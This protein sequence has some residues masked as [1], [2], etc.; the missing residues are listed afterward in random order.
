MYP[1]WFINFNKCTHINVLSQSVLSDS[2]QPYGLESTRLLCPWNPPGKNTGVGSHSLL[3]GIF[4][5]Q[6]SNWC[7]LAGSFES[8]PPGKPTHTKEK[9]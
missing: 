4:L 2:L 7:L 6:G 1:C 9:C 8:E 3:Q 5:T